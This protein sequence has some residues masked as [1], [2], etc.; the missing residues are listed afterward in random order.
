MFKGGKRERPQAILNRDAAQFSGT[1]RKLR[2]DGQNPTVITV[3]VENGMTRG[4][5]RSFVRLLVTAGYKKPQG[6][7]VCYIGRTNT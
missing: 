7:R 2:D 6:R 4:S 1:F 3:M 5:Y